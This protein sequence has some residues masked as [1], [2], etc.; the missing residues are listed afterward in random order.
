[1]VPTSLP[2]KV[3]HVSPEWH[4]NELGEVVVSENIPTHNEST[5][6]KSAHVALPRPSGVATRRCFPFNARDPNADLR[7]DDHKPEKRD[8]EAPELLQ[9]LPSKAST[10]SA[11]VGKS[12][13]PSAF[14][15]FDENDKVKPVQPQSRAPSV[16]DIITKA[17][18]LS[19]LDRKVGAE[20]TEHLTSPRAGDQDSAILLQM[21]ERLTTVLDIAESRLNGYHGTSP[22]ATSRGG[23]K[24]W[25][26]RYVDYTS[27]YGLG[28]L[29]NDGC[30]GVYFN[31]STKAVL[32]GEGDRFEYIERRKVETKEGGRR[33]EPTCEKH[34]LHAYPE[35]L[36]KKVTLLKHFR[37]Y[38]IEQQQKADD[39]SVSILESFN[40]KVP[41]SLVYLKKWVRTK[42]AILFRL[43]TQT[44]QIVFYD[45]TEILLTPDERFVTY[46]D[47][48]R[49]RST[50]YLNDELVGTN[51]ELAKRIKYSKEILQQLLVGQQRARAG[52]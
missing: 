34:T 5:Y 8:S 42:H 28:F 37:N 52:V 49:H 20:V 6:R 9:R 50:F 31:D 17:G 38:L 21:L 51:L 36:D 11:V 41:D 25:V 16:E 29:L 40:A 15:I 43:S 27:K 22:Q 39:D 30:S 18:A 14:A 44:V 19:L 10:I 2:L 4:R 13:A 23:P 12:T 47:K 32:E 1:M 46:V 24:T 3:L 45:Q 7:M 26:T 33:N 35:S 48:Q